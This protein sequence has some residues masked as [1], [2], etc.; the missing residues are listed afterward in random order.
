MVKSQSEKR[1][2]QGTPCQ[3]IVII[4]YIHIWMTEMGMDKSGNRYRV[5]RNNQKGVAL[6][7]YQ[8]K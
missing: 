2:M 7:K 1:K 8:P 5:Y 3:F 6:M 4:G